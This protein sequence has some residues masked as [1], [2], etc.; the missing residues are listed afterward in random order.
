MGRGGATSVVIYSLHYCLLVYT[1]EQCKLVLASIMVEY[2]LHIL[3]VQIVPMLAVLEQLV[4]QVVPLLKL[5]QAHGRPDYPRPLSWKLSPGLACLVDTL[6][7]VPKFG[8][9]G[10]A[11]LS[12]SRL[13]VSHQNSPTPRLVLDSSSTR[14]VPE[15]CH[16]CSHPP[17]RSLSVSNFGF[18]FLSRARERERQSP[19][20]CRWC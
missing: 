10:G 2:A 16:G 4:E 14:R 19:D 11:V 15:I 6:T 3:A 9:R 13:R 7:R 5:T 20:D 8:W 17:P 18:Q 1:M 12:L